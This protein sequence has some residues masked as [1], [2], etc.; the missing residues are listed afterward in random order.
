MVAD[1]RVPSDM[2]RITLSSRKHRTLEYLTLT[3]ELS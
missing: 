2:V 3:A 1:D